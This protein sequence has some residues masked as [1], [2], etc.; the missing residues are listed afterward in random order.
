MLKEFWI[1]TI[2]VTAAVCFVIFF[3]YLFNPW[4]YK[5]I[6]NGSAV[7]DTLTNTYQIAKRTQAPKSLSAASRQPIFTEAQKEALDKFKKEGQ[8]K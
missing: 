2:S 7:L 5:T 3:F 6:H 4:R 1:K 8:I